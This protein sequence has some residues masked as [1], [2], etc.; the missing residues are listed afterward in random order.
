M[1]DT[2]LYVINGL[3]TLGYPVYNEHFLTTDSEIPCISYYQSND[4]QKMTG[5]SLQYSKHYYS[6]KVW[7]KNTNDVINMPISIDKTMRSLG[8]T[9][10][11][12]NEL[13]IG[14]ICQVELRYEANALEIME[15]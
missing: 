8:F 5:E 1:I 15:D 12:V 14:D 4:I 11:A 10:T 3:K 6:I 13:W 9:R 2:K 7:A